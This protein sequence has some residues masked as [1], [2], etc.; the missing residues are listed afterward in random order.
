LIAATNRDLAEE[1]RARRFRSDLF[2][3]LSVFPIHVPPLRER[4]EDIAPLVA[5][6]A[7]KYGARFTRAITRIDK[8]SL[9]ALESCSWPG[10]VRELE[11]VV[12][13]AVIVSRNGILRIDPA[14]LP[15]AVVAGDMP[16]GLRGRERE[17][18]EAALANSAG[19]ISGPRG[20]AA[21][22]GVPASTL[23]SR[24]KRLGIDKFRY[25]ARRTTRS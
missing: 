2:Y 4:R 7:A 14:D 15:G 8:R 22:L 19:R 12:E 16:A 9:K 6:F 11:N 20:A 18:I 23:E 13:R 21:R 17:M 24:I 25:R 5:H 3:R 1:V 10:N